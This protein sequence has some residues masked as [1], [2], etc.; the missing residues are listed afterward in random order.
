M[1]LKEAK[2]KAA[3]VAPVKEERV[4]QVKVAKVSKEE[5][6]AK[7]G[8]EEKVAKVGRV[9]QVKKVATT[10]GV[11][12]S[13]GNGEAL[14]EVLKGEDVTGLSGQVRAYVA[15][16]SGV[17]DNVSRTELH[18]LAKQFVPFLVRLLKL[19]FANVASVP[20]GEQGKVD[21]RG[22][23]V[24]T[25]VEIALDSLDSLRS[26]FTGSPF[27]IEIQRCSFVRRLLA[28]RRHSAALVQCR[29]NLTSLCLHF[30]PSAGKDSSKQGLSAAV[31][32]QKCPVT[33]VAE[34]KR[35]PQGSV[36]PRPQDV[37]LTS[38]L[39][40]L[41][42]GIVTDL[43][44]CTGES[45][46]T[47]PECYHELLLLPRQLEPWLMA[48]DADA[49][50]KQK[51]TLYKGLYKC[52]SVLVANPT[53]YGAQLVREFSML[54]LQSCLSSSL[55]KQYVKV[56]YRL[57]QCLSSHGANNIRL[58]LDV[59]QAVMKAS[60]E[61]IELQ[62]FWADSDMLELV[63][64]YARLCQ[65]SKLSVEGCTYLC[66][67]VSHVRHLSPSVAV[68]L[69][70]YAIGLKFCS[71]VVDLNTACH[72]LLRDGAALMESCLQ[73]QR[74]EDSRKQSFSI[75]K[76]FE[77]VKKQSSKYTQGAWS[78]FVTEKKAVTIPESS[79]VT[80]TFRSVLHLW[81]LLL[82]RASDYREL[83]R[84]EEVILKQ[85]WSVASV[86]VV[87]LLRLSVMSLQG[88]QDC[89][90]CID[91][92]LKR[93]SLQIDELRWIM[94][95]ASNMGIQ[96]YN[97]KDYESAY[98][99][100]RV[101]YDA[102]WVRVEVIIQQTLSQPGDNQV[103][104]Y[105][106]DFCS[107]CVTLADSLKRSGKNQTCFEILSE[108]LLRWATIYSTL[109]FHP[110]NAPS[111][112]VHV[113]VRTLH[114]D[115]PAIRKSDT[116]EYVGLHSF[117]K[118]GCQALH[119]RTTGLL[120]EEELLVL[121]E[122]EDQGLD[123]IQLVKEQNLQTLLD[124]V[125]T[126]NEF[127][128][129]RCRILL[130][131]G[132][133]ARLKGVYDFTSFSQV[134]TVLGKILKEVLEKGADAT[135][136]ANIENQ[137]A[138]AYCAHA[139]CAYERDPAGQDYLD[140]IFSALSVWEVSARAGRTWIGLDGNGDARMLGQTACCGVSLLRL[141]HSVNDLMA[142]NGYSL[143]QC[144]V[145][146]LIVSL[147]SPARSDSG[148][149]IFSSLWENARFSHILCP[150]PY[151]SGFFSSLAQKLGVDGNSLQFWE[152]CALLCPGSL[153]D[154]QLRFMRPTTIVSTAGTC[155]E[156]FDAV[157]Q[158]A[159]SLLRTSPKS[160]LGVSKVA[161]L[162]HILAKHALDEGK[163]RVACKYAKEALSLRLRLVSRMF[164][165]KYKGD[166]ATVSQSDDAEIEAA[167][168]K[169]KA[170][171][172]HILDSVATRAWPKLSTNSKPVDLDPNPWRVFGDYV[173]SLMQIGVVSE[174]MG[175]VDDALAS[176]SE[177]YSVT[178]AQ[179]LP[180]ARA[181]FKSCLGEVQ[182]KRHHWETAE[183]ELIRAKGEFENLESAWVCS[184]CCLTGKATVL[185]RLG[186]LARRYRQGDN[187]DPSEVIHHHDAL[188]SYMASQE[189]FT[190]VLSTVNEGCEC[191]GCKYP[192]R[193]NDDK[194]KT[195]A[196]TT[197]ALVGSKSAIESE[198]HKVVS[199]DSRQE[200]I[201]VDLTASFSNLK[202]TQNESKLCDS[203]APVRRNSRRNPIDD[204][205]PFEPKKLMAKPSTRSRKPKNQEH[206]ITQPDASIE[207]APVVKPGKIARKRTLIKKCKVEEQESVLADVSIA[208]SKQDGI[209][210]AEVDTQDAG[211]SFISCRKELMSCVVRQAFGASMDNW[212][213]CKW[214]KHC[215]QQLARVNVQIGKFHV[216]AG[217]LDKVVEMFEHASFL[218]GIQVGL[219]IPCT[220]YASYSF[221]DQAKSVFPIEEAAL[222]YH[223]S[224]LQIQKLQSNGGDGIYTE[225][226]LP[227]NWLVHA[228]SL[229]TEVPPLLRKI[230][231]LLSILHV[232]IACGGLGLL[233]NLDSSCMR[234][235]AA[236]FHQV[237]IGA[238]SRQ[239][240][241]AVLD[242]KLLSLASGTEGPEH[243]ALQK[244]FSE[245]QNA[246]V[247]APLELRTEG[248]S[249]RELV[250]GLPSNTLCC[251]SLVERE[252]AALLK[253]RKLS[254]GPKLAEIFVWVLSTRYS[255]AD[256]SLTVLLPASPL[257]DGEKHLSER[258]GS[259]SNCPYNLDEPEDLKLPSAS[260][261]TKVPSNNRRNR[262][263]TSLHDIAS[264]FTAILEESR[265]STSG[266]IDIDTVEEKR[267]WWRW[268]LTLD[269]RLLQLLNSME[270]TWLGSW[271]CLLVAEPASSSIRE[272]LQ[273]CSEEL[274]CW[275]RSSYGVRQQTDAHWTTYDALVRML[276]QG[277]GSLSDD[278]T[279]EGIL[280]LLKW[281]EGFLDELQDSKPLAKLGRKNKRIDTFC[282][283]I[284][285]EAL[286]RFHKA[287]LN[288]VQSQEHKDLQQ[289]GDACA[290]VSGSRRTRKPKRGTSAR[291]NAQSVSGRSEIGFD[292]RDLVGPARESITLVLDSELQGLPWESLPV[293]RGFETYRMPSVGGIRALLVH[294]QLASSNFSSNL[295]TNKTAL[296]KTLNADLV[297]EPCVNPYNTYYVLN[298]S[299]DLAKT[300]QAFEDWFKENLGWEGKVG[301]V[302]TI[303][304]YVAGLQKHDLYTYLGHGSGD[305]YLP[306]R[307]VRRLD[308]C[309]AALL[310]GCSSGR[311]SPRGDYE[312]VGVPLSYLMAG[313]PA[314]IANL[315]DVTDG[316]I[317]RFSRFLLHKW[318]G[319]P[320]DVDMVTLE[321][322][323]PSTTE[324]CMHGS[325]KACGTVRSVIKT[326]KLFNAT[327][328]RDGEIRSKM[329]TSIGEG[330]DLCRLPY[331]I[332][333]SPV[334]YGVPTS[335]I[336][337]EV[338]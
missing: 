96:L 262:F 188:S 230:S 59:S 99:P 240:H 212:T 91:Y 301:Q 18:K 123:S 26:F 95:S 322:K 136:I 130:E 234:E 215:H 265:A 118:T 295:L 131:R 284:G 220:D 323:V 270:N 225:N 77:M 54:A 28:W 290:D 8:K 41:V 10:G 259:S 171:R 84:E 307:F 310:M 151:P 109:Q 202:L 128:V 6:V 114:A 81:Y 112:L 85:G 182:R 83:T 61:N 156:A 133:Q 117:L 144:R 211:A 103:N 194:D 78:S 242:S 113:W 334:Y 227:M 150:V 288:V 104:D 110:T 306:E 179:N 62:S 25:A 94:A 246:L 82:R 309:A 203:K 297:A 300:Q 248:L 149:K 45:A 57:S 55:R 315:W 302:P 291:T 299:G 31:K 326:D 44:W 27:E 32:G 140:S 210:P 331:L 24:F 141:L 231:R 35:N 29:K 260:A 146:Q 165:T 30:S 64:G 34:K 294:Q 89:L 20:V 67:L 1:A 138:M 226:V 324:A 120:L 237:S 292:V 101:A 21:R 325:K 245:M 316:D 155:C 338:Q 11:E 200:L 178:S 181:A 79:T 63:D 137:L 16:L 280:T 121:H 273:I 277:L 93:G 40:A 33:V 87:S 313:C 198:N 263:Q 281:I 176:F 207:V 68:I 135:E 214:V 321:Q 169:N 132:R 336:R 311:F 100:F 205:I 106:L 235:R 23:E 134:I 22:D 19:C 107:K 268:R 285:A 333:A 209:V 303:E 148:P 97:N 335:I 142:L 267:Q 247:V 166:A 244:C 337:R 252:Q 223:K 38:G 274:G 332:G 187:P 243:F 264:A 241:L 43:I 39:P 296:E 102:A 319:T 255:D 275:L 190:A 172:L 327:E 254:G 167:D 208:G 174:K 60:Y 213:A 312:P 108:G 158:I 269:T 175:A 122:L 143:V 250:K 147:L 289:G 236:F 75:L 69:G 139:F 164:H 98:Y 204:T 271:K 278:Q 180:L 154:A 304:E 46:P 72:E 229:S 9:A 206:D 218:L 160:S 73:Q 115:G 88:V 125:Y 2:V 233:H 272:S 163:L 119:N 161:A 184:C 219:L 42:S 65:T 90:T 329:G 48:L 192:G 189:T 279:K 222:L 282:E 232:P 92:L 7:V 305:Q 14:L 3:R 13:G 159:L 238:G 66:D 129:E 145:Q 162:F 86:P 116:R 196:S 15:P 105:M 320:N 221:M 193:S 185:L 70:L 12:E 50:G 256:G 170:G 37:E 80:S 228:Y 283:D 168:Q 276:L 298:P 157:E 52:V 314:A 191:V 257:L 317:D 153:L 251:V 127:P 216:E 111:S 173:E 318:L 124:N 36:L 186:D 253:Q 249:I 58:G 197:P 199:I 258:A 217:N 152:D 53:H 287:Y 56:A 49:A 47:S 177:G 183:S 71:D 4:A 201:E 76:S 195:H 224:L 266:D 308:R 5:K 293:L 330:R 328:S 286:D 239:Q 51:D 261:N 74:E 17:K 126:V